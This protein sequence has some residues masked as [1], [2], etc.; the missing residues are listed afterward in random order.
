MY[1]PLL[2][3]LENGELWRETVRCS[4]VGEVDHLNTLDLRTGRSWVQGRLVSTARF[5]Q[6]Q[7]TSR[8]YFRCRGQAFTVSHL[9]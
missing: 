5:D 2:V 4:F 8:Q 3:S 7:L 1:R 6:G 9:G